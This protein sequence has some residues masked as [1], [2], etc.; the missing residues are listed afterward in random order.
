LTE[1]SFPVLPNLYDGLL[2]LRANRQFITAEDGSLI[3]YFWVDAI[4]IGRDNYAEKAIQ[5][6]LMGEI[7]QM[8]VAVMVWLG[9]DIDDTEEIRDSIQPLAD[10]GEAHI[11]AMASDNGFK[12]FPAGILFSETNR[13]KILAPYGLRGWTTDRWKT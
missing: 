5:V 10:T 1:R 3:D 8:S 12:P 7:Y 4:C 6:N 9:K 13:Q 11:D 2:Q